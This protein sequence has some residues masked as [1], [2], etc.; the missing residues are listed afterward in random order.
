MKILKGKKIIILMVVISLITVAFTG[1]SKFSGTAIMKAGNTNSE[2]MEYK[3][4]Y[5]NGTHSASFHMK[6]GTKVLI[7][8]DVVVEEGSL[9]II[10]RKDDEEAIWE[11]NIKEDT[12]DSV[13]L[14]F[15][16]EGKYKILAVGNK[17]KGRFKITYNEI[18]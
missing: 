3:Y 14:T 11:V 7:E 18:K 6:E 10:V 15:D 2:K 12:K 4:K 17:T 9:D 5:L 1:C 13:E 8:Y 16:D